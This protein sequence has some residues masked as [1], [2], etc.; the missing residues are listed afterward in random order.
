MLIAYGR[1]VSCPTG[2][3]QLP[4]GLAARRPEL[5]APSPHAHRVGT[6]ERALDSLYASGRRRLRHAGSLDTNMISPDR[7]GTSP[8]PLRRPQSPA[9]H[10]TASS[11]SRLQASPDSVISIRRWRRA[12]WPPASSVRLHRS[13]C[14]FPDRLLAAINTRPISPGCSKTRLGAIRPCAPGG[15]PWWAYRCSACL[16]RSAFD[17]TGRCGRICRT[18]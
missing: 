8:P 16:Q 2:V 10:S 3:W 12:C 18:A 4:P 7:I 5:Q 1:G 9:P 13:T 11:R 15:L 17:S 6:V 14:R